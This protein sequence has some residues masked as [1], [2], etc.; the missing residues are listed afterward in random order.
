MSKFTAILRKLS[1]VILIVTLGLT[2][3]PFTSA[4]AAEMEAHSPARPNDVRLENMWIREQA[5]YKIQGNRL[6]NAS[7]FIE[8]IQNLINRA[9]A[10]GWDTSSV[11][12]ALD[13]LSKVIP[14]VQAAHDPGAAIITSHTGFDSDGNVTDRAT[15]LKTVRS[16][17]QVLKDSRSAMN[18]TG[19]A[20]RDAIRAFRQAHPRP[21]ATPV[22]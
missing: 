11:Q 1:L 20:L 6:D 15:A 9:T 16:L 19:A 5:A 13:E 17:R 18:G 10:K 8:N 12:A 7:T 3:F 14:E 22:Q 4:S 2:I 21:S